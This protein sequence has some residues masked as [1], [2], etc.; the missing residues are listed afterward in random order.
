[1]NRQIVYPGAIP[2]ETDLL[3]TNK[4]SMLG[5]AKLASSLMGGNTYVHGLACTPSSPASM[6]VNVSAG[7]IYSLQNIDGTAYSSLPA[8]T[9]HS[10]LRKVRISH[11]TQKT[12]M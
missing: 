4:Y 12:P 11:Q 9:T 6:V 2:L 3:N 1:M 8:D 10:I 5:L 7:Q